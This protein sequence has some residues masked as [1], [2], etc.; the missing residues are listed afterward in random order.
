[1]WKGSN[2]ISNDWAG[3]E[4]H[5]KI[6]SQCVWRGKMWIKIDAWLVENLL[7]WKLE[8]LIKLIWIFMRFPSKKGLN[9]LISNTR[10][11]HQTS[12]LAEIKY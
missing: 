9:K 2:N 3:G 4:K 12:D 1:M 6:K 11:S 5:K 7:E 8:Y 10:I